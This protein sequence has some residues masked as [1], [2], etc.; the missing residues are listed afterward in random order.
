MPLPL[1]GRRYEKDTTLHAAPDKF[2]LRLEHAIQY[3]EALIEVI[4]AREPSS[5]LGDRAAA[6]SY[7]VFFPSLIPFYREPLA[8]VSRAA[9]DAFLA[10]QL[11][12]KERVLSVGLRW[13]LRGD[14][15]A[16]HHHLPPPTTHEN[17]ISAIAILVFSSPL[18][19]WAMPRYYQAAGPLQ[20]FPAGYSGLALPSENGIAQ[21]S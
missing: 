3:I 18:G 11:G 1:V 16:I 15:L 10:R 8:S 7:A 6:I 17:T 4:E 13:H 5:S 19:R 21:C 12:F 9:R 20:S 14:A 2:L